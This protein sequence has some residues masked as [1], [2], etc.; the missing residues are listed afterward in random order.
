MD[1]KLIST[2]NIAILSAVKKRDDLCSD[3]AKHDPY[4][5]PKAKG[6]ISILPSSSSTLDS[7]YLLMRPIHVKHLPLL[8][9]S[10]EFKKDLRSWIEKAQEKNTVLTTL[11]RLHLTGLRFLCSANGF[12][13]ATHATSWL[14]VTSPGGFLD[15][16]SAGMTP[17]LLHSLSPSNEDME[18]HS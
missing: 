7:I 4:R 18:R 17:T 10:L 14:L 9:D 12:T 1:T 15:L 13:S 5:S 11:D 3:T 6:P 2:K 16:Q 8:S